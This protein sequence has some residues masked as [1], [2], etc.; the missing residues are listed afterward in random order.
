MV[1]NAA[2]QMLGFT[3]E[4]LMELNVPGIDPLYDKNVWDGF[5]QALIKEKNIRLVTKHIRKDGTLIDVQID[6]HY[7][8]FEN[9]EMSCAFVSD[10][11]ERKLAETLLKNSE[12]RYRQIAE[13]AQEG[14]WLI[15]ENDCTNFINKKMCEIVEYSEDELMGKKI[16]DFMDEE[17]HKKA[18][19]QIERR[20]Q[21]LSEIH[22]AVFVTKTGKH[23]WVTV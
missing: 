20:K 3:F 10:I 12:E 5:W 16:Y 4:E 18:L 17:S 21:G 23:V 22:D 1:N 19:I 7:F 13:T 8:K 2:T 11:T 15:D 9:I 6:T 14:I